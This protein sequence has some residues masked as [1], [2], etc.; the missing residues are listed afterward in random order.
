MVVVVY[1]LIAL[2][3]KFPSGATILAKLPH[4]LI[5]SVQMFLYSSSLLVKPSQHKAW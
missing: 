5:N 3:V 1:I 2:P 4:T